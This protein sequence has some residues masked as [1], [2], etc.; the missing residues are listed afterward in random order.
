MLR[1]LSALLVL[2]EHS[3]YY[4]CQNTDTPWRSLI[5]IDF[6]VLGVLLFFCI[7]GFVIGTLRTMSV[8]QF[9][10][11]RVLRIYPAY[12][13]AYALTALIVLPV[14]R[15][16]FDLWAALLLP[17]STLPSIYIQIWTLIYE[18]FFYATAA[19]LFALRLGD[20]GLSVAMLLWILAAQF[21]QPYMHT[22]STT[23]P[24][25]MLPLSPYT[26]LFAL[27]M[28]AAI[29]LDRIR[30]LQPEWSIAIAIAA[31][32]LSQSLPDFPDA[33]RTLLLG[34]SLCALLAAAVHVRS[35]WRPLSVLG[36]GSY[37]LYLI[38]NA[39]VV[40]LGILLAPLGINALALA[41]I[42]FVGGLA[43]GVT[44]GLIEMRWYRMA[45]KWLR[46]PVS[47]LNQPA[48]VST[49]AE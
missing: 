44:F 47:P 26:Q 45:T 3:L 25:A 15:T 39:V 36:D 22:V 1:G 24:G 2:L 23:L 38:H 10:L 6:G 21:A 40:T 46:T 30:R 9:L 8:R 7:S 18:V 14:G 43:I 28:L 33:R 32:V 20:R 41:G 19:C 17:A 48:L 12:W 49:P 16:D 5:K 29:N 27:G 35:I 42:L 4:A 11:R 34:V 37:G 31:L 13:A